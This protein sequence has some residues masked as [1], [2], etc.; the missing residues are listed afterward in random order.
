MTEW[1]EPSESESAL[2]LVQE[3]LTGKCCLSHGEGGL[4][5]F[6]GVT[7]NSTHKFKTSELEMFI[8][9]L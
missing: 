6:T 5:H 7:G 1:P 2:K 9:V 3:F 4:W 8:S